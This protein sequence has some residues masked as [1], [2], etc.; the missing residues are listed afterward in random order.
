MERKIQIKIIED[1]GPFK[2]GKIVTLKVYA[3]ECYS[4]LNFQDLLDAGFGVII[5][6]NTEEAKRINEERAIAWIKKVAP[7][8]WEK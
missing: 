7:Y 3:P 4:A 8:P 5:S 1:I 6:D 2:K